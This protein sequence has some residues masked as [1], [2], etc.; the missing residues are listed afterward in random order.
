MHGSTWLEPNQIYSNGQQGII[1][2]KGYSASSPVDPVGSVHVA[3][4]DTGGGEIPSR[5]GDGGEESL[6]QRPIGPDHQVRQGPK[7]HRPLF[8]PPDHEKVSMAALMM[9][10]AER[11]LTAVFLSFT[12]LQNKDRSILALVLAITTNYSWKNN[13][14][15]KNSS[16]YQIC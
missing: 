1:P 4:W 9:A 7:V 3:V 11:T 15:F 6:G 2:P 14:L 10:K 16:S 13:E 12:G 5:E 8:E